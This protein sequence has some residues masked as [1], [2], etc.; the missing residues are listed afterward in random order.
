MNIDKLKELIESSELSQLQKNV[1]NGF[2]QRA[3][4][5]QERKSEDRQLIEQVANVK[6]LSEVVLSTYE[7]KIYTVS[8]IDEWDIKYP[9]RSIYLDKQGK[10]RRVNTVAPTL[11]TAFLNYLEYKHIGWNTRF[12]DFAI[13]MLEIKLEE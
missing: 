2:I 10:W 5:E 12:A 13:K 9:F 11:D 7:V 1:M 8:G 3:K 6:N 4:D